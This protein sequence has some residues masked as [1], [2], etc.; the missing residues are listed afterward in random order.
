MMLYHAK[1]FVLA[2]QGKDLSIDLLM[3]RRHAVV[4]KMLMDEDPSA[5]KFRTRHIDRDI[6]NLG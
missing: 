5:V 4:N 1:I 3:K 2:L 6:R